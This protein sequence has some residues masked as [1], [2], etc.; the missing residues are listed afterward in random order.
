VDHAWPGESCRARTSD[1][2]P[3]STAPR[4]GYPIS[5]SGR[6]A[7]GLAQTS[8][9]C[10]WKGRSSWPVPC[11]PVTR[12][13]PSVPYSDDVLIA[14][15]ES[16]MKGDVRKERTHGIG[17][18]CSFQVLRRLS[19]R[20]MEHRGKPSRELTMIGVIYVTGRME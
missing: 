4:S 11:S 9:S 10:P 18:K 15:V 20:G 16:T 7:W 14:A 1:R 13:I 8:G 12:S 19:C 3:L 6:A 2:R 5:H 17:A